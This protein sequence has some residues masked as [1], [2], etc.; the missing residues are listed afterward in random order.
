MATEDLSPET[1]EALKEQTGESTGD[2]EVK[3]DVENLEGSDDSG[4][5]DDDINLNLEDEEDDKQGDDKGESE[6][7]PEN[8]A[9]DQK[10]KEAGFDV[11]EIA[12]KIA[13]NNGEIP[14]DVIKAAKE[15]FN[16]DLVDA[17]VARLKS[18]FKLAQIEASEKY[19]EFQ[20]QAKKTQEMNDYI[21]KSVGGED[22][23]KSLATTLRGSLDKESLESINAKLLSGNKTLVNEALKTAVSEYKKLKGIG[24][25]LMEGDANTPAQKEL[26]ITKEEYRAI[27]KT[28]KY[29]TD[30]LYQRKID[31]ARLKTRQADQK[32]YGPGMYYGMNQNG[33]YEL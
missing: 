32:R 10:L 30:P 8:K 15:K 18:E 16:P 21:Y 12:K 7:T 5:E 25:K 6:G 20:E 23:F 33:R 22:K 31:E 29:K 14:E 2:E 11:D 9:V 4:S 13:D 1:L 17:H 27:M 24:G 28:E 3:P 19:K 26:R